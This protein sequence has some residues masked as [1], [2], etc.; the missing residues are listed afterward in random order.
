MSKPVNFSTS[1]TLTTTRQ[2]LEPTKGTNTFNNTTIPASS[3]SVVG[4]LS[5]PNTN[6]VNNHP[7][8]N[9]QDWIGPKRKARPMKHYRRQLNRTPGSGYSKISVSLVDRPGSTVFRGVTDTNC[10]CTTADN[11][12]LTLNNKFLYSNNHTIKPPAQ[13]PIIPGTNNNK[14]QNNGSINIGNKYEIQ[15]GVYNTVSLCYSKTKDAKKLTRN[16][17]IL[18]KSYYTTTK[19]YLKARCNLYEQK[20]SIQKIPTETYNSTNISENSTKFYTNNC[21]NPY[22][23]GRNCNNVTYYNPNNTQFKTQGAVSSSTRLLA[24]NVNT[25]TKNG[26]SFRSAWGDAAA[27]AGDYQGTS[28]SPYFVKSKYTPKLVYRKSGNKN[29]CTSNCGPSTVLSSFWGGSVN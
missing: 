12:Y 23:T 17:T 10:S 5:R 28:M 6:G 8:Y 26:N 7:N 15:T 19:A 18:S 22:Q 11:E 16:N 3:F 14:V 24:L 2:P 1:N 13:E 27:N 25:I 9:A 29:S 21:T 4:A 20:Q